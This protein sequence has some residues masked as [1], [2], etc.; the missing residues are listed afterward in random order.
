MSPLPLFQKTLTI[1]FFKF[2][3][4][5]NE[6]KRRHENLDHQ[7]TLANFFYRNECIFCEL[8]NWY[9][10]PTFSI[11]MSSNNQPWMWHYAVKFLTS[12]FPAMKHY[13]LHKLTSRLEIQ[14]LWY[15]TLYNNIK[16][17]W[18]NNWY[19]SVKYTKKI[20]GKNFNKYIKSRERILT[21]SKWK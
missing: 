10:I 11:F 7:K 4:F 3:I 17:V 13:Y 12:F 2:F 8:L 14:N 18:S 6:S 16:I 1:L 15:Y 19:S 5:L 20:H 21:L 9:M